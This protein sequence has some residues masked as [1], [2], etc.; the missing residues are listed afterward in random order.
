MAAVS[1]IAGILALFLRRRRKAAL[2]LIGAATLAIVVVTLRSVAPG[3][4]DVDSTKR[5]IQL[6]GERGYTHAPL[7]GLQ[8]D[9]RSPEFYAAGRVIYGADHEPVMYEGIGQVIYESHLRKE[10]VLFLIPLR[11][12]DGLRQTES[13]R[14]DAIADNGR[15]AIVA[16]APL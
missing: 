5:L 13:L 14:I 9:D 6:A 16:V 2:I 8:R 3:L 12:L 7:F 4:A 15:V 11:D 10:T 1:G